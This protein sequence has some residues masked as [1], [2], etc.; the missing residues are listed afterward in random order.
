MPTKFTSSE[1]AFQANENRC[2]I[3]AG[4]GGIKV[5]SEP[6]EVWYFPRIF[7]EEI[8]SGLGHASYS[9]VERIT[10]ERV[11]ENRGVLPVSCS[12]K[13]ELIVCND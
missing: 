13:A 1:H 11:R 9:V 12:Q 5:G 7:A 2:V 8:F 4:C 6:V 10:I 3:R